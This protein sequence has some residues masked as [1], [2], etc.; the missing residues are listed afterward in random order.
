MKKLWR[1]ILILL[2]SLPFGMKAVNEVLTT[3]QKDS[4]D[5]AAVA[6]QLVNKPGTLVDVL[7]GEETQ[8]V[9]ELRWEM[10]KSD[11]L[12]SNYKYVGNGVAEKIDD[13][14]EKMKARRKKF[15]QENITLEY[16]TD[17]AL[18]LINEQHYAPDNLPARKLLKITYDNP[19]VKFKFETYCN[20]IE[21]NTK[22]G[23]FTKMHFIDDKSL[24][25]NVPF[26]NAIKKIANEL[27]QIGSDNKE[28]IEAYLS[29]QEICTD[30]TG[31]EFTTYRASNN[32][33]NGIDFKFH[34]PKFIGIEEKGSDLVIKH[35][36]MEFDGD[37]LLSEKYYSESAKKKNDEHAPREQYIK[38]ITAE[39]LEKYKI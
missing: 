4:T 26:V 29:R 3:S 16:T 22:K 24:K 25:K 15:T 30:M 8:E 21:V 34:K 11:E 1:N 7:R 31:L 18:K 39:E 13:S 38:A 14:D 33:P 9:Q 6:Q 37:V 32:V 23:F 27:N 2:H 19:N 12:A 28:M 17:E 10:Y 5:E 35:Q 36:W 20:K